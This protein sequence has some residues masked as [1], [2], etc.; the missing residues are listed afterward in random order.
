MNGP[1]RVELVPLDKI[2]KAKRNPKAHD[3]E[4][5][6]QLLVKFGLTKPPIENEKT[7]R[8]VAGHG[9][10]EALEELHRRDPKKPPAG[11]SLD[12]KGA[13]LIP[14]LRGL[15][16]KSEAAAEEYLLA[17]NQWTIVGGWDRSVLVPM[18]ARHQKIP[19][20]TG[21]DGWPEDDV[22]RM[23]AE[24][25]AGRRKPEKESGDNAGAIR[26]IVIYFRANEFEEIVSRIQAVAAS[27]KVEDHTA[28]FLRLL[29]NY[30]AHQQRP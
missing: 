25:K 11:V 6:I 21:L 14:I 13:W 4:Y 17:D 8:L 28:A 20:L 9:R 15:S 12:P 24:M 22:A 26:Q 3:L 10:V 16:F 7:G 23:I 1:A 19:E 18:L 5:L 2:Q 30:E 29:D 27:E